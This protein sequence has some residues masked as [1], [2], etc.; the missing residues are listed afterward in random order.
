MHVGS[1]PFA[2]A[3]C[4]LLCGTCPHQGCLSDFPERVTVSLSVTADELHPKDLN[5]FG[6]RGIR[7][8]L[9]L[10]RSAQRTCECDPCPQRAP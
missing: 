1:Q 7:M 6:E 3:F 5:N 10:L 8:P 4:G 2:H 9:A